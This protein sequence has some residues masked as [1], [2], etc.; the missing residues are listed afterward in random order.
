L[1]AIA[2]FIFR[3]QEDS[4]D[5]VAVFSVLIVLIYQ[6]TFHILKGSNIKFEGIV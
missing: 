5:E 6:R 1:D 3:I 4:E 2:L